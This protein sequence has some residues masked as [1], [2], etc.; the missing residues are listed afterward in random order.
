MTRFL[1][2]A[3]IYVVMSAVA[4][5]GVLIGIFPKHPNTI[6]GWLLLL[7]LALPLTIAGELVG[8]FIWRNRVAQAVETNTAGRSLS[9]LRIVYAFVAMLLLFG[10]VFAVGQFMESP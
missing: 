8:E 4:A 2:I 7:A 6:N 5:V 3:G 9:G 1:K 10:L